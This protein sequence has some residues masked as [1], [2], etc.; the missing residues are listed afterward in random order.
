[1]VYPCISLQLINQL[2]KLHRVVMIP[3]WDQ[4]VWSNLPAPL[5]SSICP[6]AAAA[7]AR[8]PEVSEAGH[9]SAAI[10]VDTPDIVDYR[11]RITR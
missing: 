1:M 6:A 8:F 11:F 5:V 7:Q 4:T 10:T 2:T 9:A 3:T